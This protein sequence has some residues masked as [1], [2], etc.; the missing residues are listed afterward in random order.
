MHGANLGLESYSKISHEIGRVCYPATMPNHKSVANPCRVAQSLTQLQSVSQRSHP[1]VKQPR[2]LVQWDV[3]TPR[4]T[5]PLWR[6]H[7]RR[8]KAQ[9]QG[10][11]SSGEFPRYSVVNPSFRFLFC[12]LTLQGDLSGWQLQCSC[13]GWPTGYGKKLSWSQSQLVQAT[14]LAVA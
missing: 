2:A 13:S 12:P 1:C 10:R 4:F 6:M 14:C 8:G 11:S 7:G 9:G 5:R 3:L